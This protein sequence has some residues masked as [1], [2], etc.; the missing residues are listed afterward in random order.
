V[1]GGVIGSLDGDGESVLSSVMLSGCSPDDD[2][3]EEPEKKVDMRD[4]AL[5][6]NA[7]VR[8]ESRERNGGIPPNV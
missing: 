4:V 3:E 8:C 5:G 7:A 6:L 2:A 1:F